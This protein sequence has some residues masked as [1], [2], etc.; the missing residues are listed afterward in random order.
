MA[1]LGLI[2]PKQIDNRFRGNQAA[3]ALLVVL[4]LGRAFASFAQIGI[5]PLLP[6]REALEHFEGVP[7]GTFGPEAGEAALVLFAWWGVASLVLTFFGILVLFR[8]RSL[9]PLTLLMMAGAKIGEIACAE[10]S[11]LTGMLGIG[12]P[13]P[14]IAAG[15]TLLAFVLAILPPVTIRRKL[16]RSDGVNA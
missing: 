16:Q 10:A 13:M 7:L 15:M 1:M 6:R 14:L 11:P 8:Y 5:N 12:A 9:I 2:F 4:L 3:F